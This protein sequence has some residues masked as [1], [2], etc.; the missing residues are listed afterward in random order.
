VNAVAAYL[1]AHRG[2]LGLDALGVPE[3]PVCVLLTPRHRL[4]RHVVTLVLAPGGRE[5]VLVAKEPRLRG[6]GAGLA[7]EAASLRAAERALRRAG[8]PNGATAPR[9]V[10][11]DDG[12]AGPL[13]LQTALRGRPL[14]RAAL[15]RDGGVVDEVAAWLRRLAVATRHVPADGAWFDRLIGAPLQ[16][17]AAR[18]RGG[19]LAAMVDRT[20]ALAQPLRCARLPLVLEHGDLAHPNLLRG[21]DRRLGVLDWERGEPDGLPAHD[22]LFFLAYA[23]AAMSR[24][25]MAGVR[26]AFAGRH[27]WGRELAE[28][29][30]AALDLNPWMLQP[31][32]AVS[33]ARAVAAFGPPGPAPVDAVERHLVLWRVALADGSQW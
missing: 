22:L 18:A 8:G 19:E 6:D 30:A 29:Y 23:A 9:L 10:A 15:R 21:P 25:R 1:T 32:L 28:R 12:P 31:L 3:R 11:F 7:R 26:S 14:S 16:T 24:G 4:S 5:P 27:A 13:L 33:A 2:R 20:L 17:L